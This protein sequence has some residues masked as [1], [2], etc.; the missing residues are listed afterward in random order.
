MRHSGVAAAVLLCTTWLFARTSISDPMAILTVFFS[1]LSLSNFYFVYKANPIEFL[2]RATLPLWLFATLL[3]GGPMGLLAPVTGISAFVITKREWRQLPR[4]FGLRELLIFFALCLLWVELRWDGGTIF[5]FASR[6]H[7]FWYVPRLFVGLLPW[8][9]VYLFFIAR[10]VFRKKLRSD[11]ARFLYTAVWANFVVMSLA[12]PK[13]GL[14]LLPVYPLM[15]YLS[16]ALL[17][18]GRKAQR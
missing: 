15:A 9:P 18:R 6:E 4:W 2:T 17:K 16:S 1:T 3:C 10:G 8:A 7:L 14:Y 12:G 5:T 13:S 11:M